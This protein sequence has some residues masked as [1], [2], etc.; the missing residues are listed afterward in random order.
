MWGQAR[1]PR[2]HVTT[3]GISKP[4]GYADAGCL[5]PATIQ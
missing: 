3:Y 1:K 4:M 2:I 5:V